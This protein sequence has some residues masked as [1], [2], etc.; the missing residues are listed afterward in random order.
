MATI[1]AQDLAQTVNCT[2]EKE[3][4]TIVDITAMSRILLF[5]VL[6]RLDQTRIDYDIVYTEAGSEY[7]SSPIIF[8]GSDRGW[9][10]S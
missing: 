8:C 7:F 5:D 2:A 6:A 3:E 4:W 9:C 1:T 10:Q